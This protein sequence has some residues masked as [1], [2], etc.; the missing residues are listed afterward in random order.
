MFVFSFSVP[1]PVQLGRGPLRRSWSP[2]VVGLLDTCLALLPIILYHGFIFLIL[3]KVTSLP[4]SLKLGCR[5]SLTCSGKSLSHSAPSIEPHQGLNGT[6]RHESSSSPLVFVFTS[7]WIQNLASFPVPWLSWNSQRREGQRSMAL[8]S[9]RSGCS[10]PGL[11]GTP[12][13]GRVSCSPSSFCIL[14]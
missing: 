11:R 14:T 6:Q 7:R 5:A 2:N 13:L 9:S 4:L 3:M 1:L 8:H 12:V 10:P